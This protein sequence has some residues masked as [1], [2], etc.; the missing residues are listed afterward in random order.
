[1]PLSLNPQE[2]NFIFELPSSFVPNEI[3]VKY[4]KY[5]VAEQHIFDSVQDLINESIQSITLPGLDLPTVTQTNKFGKEIIHRGSK[6]PVDTFNRKFTITFQTTNGLIN[7][8]IMQDLLLYHY[9]KVY[10]T[11]LEGFYIT[12]LNDN[13]DEIYR[14]NL[15]NVIFTSLSDYTFNYNAVETKS[16]TFTAGFVCNYIDPIYIPPQHLTEN[17]TQ[18]P[19]DDIN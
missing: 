18:T 17:P 10:Q 2:N 13:R 4:R 8:L 15:R 9:I 14:Y 6:A 5:L 3:E 19:L 11:H 12:V 1:M 16:H 7:Y